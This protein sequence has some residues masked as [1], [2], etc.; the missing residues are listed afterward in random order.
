TL[1][2]PVPFAMPAALTPE[3]W[4]GVAYLGIITSGIGFG[5]WKYL[6]TKRSSA[7][8]AVFNNLQPVITTVFTIVI[9]GMQPSLL[10]LIGGAITLVG[11]IL[12]Q[13]K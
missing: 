11:V 4:T 2:A 9:F 8:V 6:L 12:T 7:Q 13:R 5:L 3:Q 10:F 1:L